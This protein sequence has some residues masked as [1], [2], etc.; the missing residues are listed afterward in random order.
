MS[1]APYVKTQEE[2]VELVVKSGA[3]INQGDPVGY[4]SGW[5][6]ANGYGLYGASPV[7]TIP[8]QYISL[9]SCEGDGVKK[10][11]AV[12]KCVII[13]EDAPFTDNGAVYLHG[14]ATAVP[15]GMITQT[16]PTGAGYLKQVLG[17]ATSTR[18]LSIDI[19]PFREE[20]ILIPRTGYNQQASG[21][22]VEAC[23]VDAGWAGTLA[24]AAAI[25]EVFNGRLPDNL[26]SVDRAALLIDTTAGTALDVDASIVGTFDNLANN[27]DTGTAVTGATSEIATA[28]NLVNAV[29]LLALFDSGIAF[30]GLI[31]AVTIDPDAGTGVVVGLELRLTLC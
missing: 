21:P 14:V 23:G 5:V 28:D 9:D 8:A 7:A 29:D 13:D 27:L 12:R 17:R 3:I 20:T 2:P 1:Y 4:S 25:A 6:L 22:A 24:D 11:K 31:Y 26:V 10:I 16:R 18:A 30:P 19:R 15:G